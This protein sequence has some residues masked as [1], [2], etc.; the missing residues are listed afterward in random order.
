MGDVMRQK[1]HLLL[2]EDQSELRALYSLV[3]TMCGYD[4]VAVEHAE[5]A[6][7]H[8]EHNGYAL[9][10]TDWQLPGMQ[11][12]ELIRMA[13][14]RFPSVKTMLMSAHHHVNDAARDCHA[15]AWYRKTWDIGRLRTVVDALFAD[16]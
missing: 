7:Y 5:D 2:V 13:R 11:G 10:L 1:R 3:L 6:V 12:D 16:D 15:H 9:L 14:D 8:L 4:V